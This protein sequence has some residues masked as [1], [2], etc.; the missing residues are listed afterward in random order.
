MTNISK[1]E[2]KTDILFINKRRHT[3]GEN[4]NVWNPNSAVFSS[5]LFNS[6]AMIVTMMN[7]AGKN[8]VME[9]AID[10]NCIDRLVTQYRPRIVIIEALWVIPS[11]FEILHRLHP[12]VKWIVRLH[13]EFP[14]LSNEGIAFE[15]L[16]YYSEQYPV[17][18]IASNSI[19]AQAELQRLF[20]VKVLLLPNYYLTDE[21]YSVKPKN[22]KV[23]HVSCFGA[24]RPL[25]NTLIQAMAAVKYA[26]MHKKTLIFHINGTRI[27]GNAGSILKNIRALFKPTKHF[28]IEHDWLEHNEFKKLIREIIDI[29]L[30]VSFSESYNIVAADHID[31]D[32]PIVT[33]NEVDFV[34]SKFKADPTDLDGIVKTMG[35]ALLAKKWHI[36]RINNFYL[37]KSNKEAFCKW[38]TFLENEV[39]C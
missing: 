22:N 21:D 16:Q 36:N 1:P 31:C 2:F 32:I 15:W 7:G 9:E 13:S 20:K 33:S 28:L 18:T 38:L 27:E 10:N 8:V 34:S 29:G 19:R 12:E 6:V 35:T 25:K 23:I 26:D 37:R 24:I 30:Q 17:V 11:K 39:N 14:F 4:C 3:Y 5:G